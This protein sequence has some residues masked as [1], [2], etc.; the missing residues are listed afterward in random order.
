LRSS[1][2]DLKALLWSKYWVGTV[3]LLVLALLLTGLTNLELK[4][5]MFMMVMSLA[6][7]FALTIAIAALALGFGALYPQ[8]ET[9][10]AAQIPTSFG[11]LV[12]MMAT[13]ALLAAVIISLWQA[14]HEYLRAAFDGRPVVVDAW[15]IGWF[16]LAGLLCATATVVP[17]RVG[18]RKME[19]FEF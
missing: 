15:M 16:V 7:I 10:N 12:F 6:T 11:G 8:F 19:E 9:E 18:L 3:P 4:V 2:L 1:P 5:S 17:L 13:V 14:V